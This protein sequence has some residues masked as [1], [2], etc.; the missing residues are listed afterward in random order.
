VRFFFLTGVALLLWGCG[1]SSHDPAVLKVG[2]ELNY[3]PFEMID[4]NGQPSGVG[5]DLAKALGEKLG[6][7]IQIENQ[8]FDGLIPALKTGKIDLVIS[9]LTANAERAQSIDF[10]DPY[11]H[12]GLSILAGKNSPVQSSADLDQP[13]RVVTVKKGTTG[14]SYAVAH[15][16]H[17]TVLVL[18]QDATCA[19]EVSQG[20]ADAFVYDQI[21]VL[22]H[23][24]RNPESTRALL[25]PF[26]KESWAIGIRKGNDDL[27][28]EVNQFLATFKKEGGFDRLAEKYLQRPKAVF[29]KLGYPFFFDEP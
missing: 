23:W 29:Q 17:A 20:K 21:S 4:T 1:Q 14:H 11:V 18:D 6:K 12:T 7:K 26:Q 8:P 27:R 5:V 19:L 16:T 10:S 24:E 13:G 2:M 9:S 15:L 25:N 28:R 3:P 22:Q